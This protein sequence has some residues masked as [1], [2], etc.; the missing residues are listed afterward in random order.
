MAVAV[1][2]MR[3]GKKG[4]P[5]YRVVVLDKRSKRDGAYLESIGIY[6]PLKQPHTLDLQQERFEYWVSR[7]AQISEGLTRLLKSKNKP[8]T[9]PAVKKEAK[10]EV[11]HEKKA[12]AKKTPKKAS[13]EEAKA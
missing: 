6:N 8:E 1:R 10:A 13:K 7:G 9:K 4:Q 2:L 12:P 3:F 11:K 5:S